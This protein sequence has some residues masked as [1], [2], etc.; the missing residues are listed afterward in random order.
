MDDVSDV[1][2]ADF[3]TEV[4][5]TDSDEMMAEEAPGAADVPD[6]PSEDEPAPEPSEPGTSHL[7][8]W[9]VLQPYKLVTPNCALCPDRHQW[10]SHWVDLTTGQ[11]IPGSEWF[12]SGTVLGPSVLGLADHDGGEIMLGNGMHHQQPCSL[13]CSL[14]CSLSQRKLQAGLRCCRLHSPCVCNHL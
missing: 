1:P 11:S 10:P 7:E 12:P 3:A 2:E 8:I 14:P 13:A 9:Q 6:P 4:V 5:V